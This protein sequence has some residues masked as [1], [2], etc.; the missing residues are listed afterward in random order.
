VPSAMPAIVR[1]RSRLLHVLA[2]NRH[3]DIARLQ[4][5][6]GGRAAGLGLI[7]DGAFGLF[8]FEAFGDVLRHSLDL[9]PSSPG[10]HSLTSARHPWGR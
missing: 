8:H 7:D 9:K 6:P 3:N 2:V 4:A 5:G 10:Q 1:A